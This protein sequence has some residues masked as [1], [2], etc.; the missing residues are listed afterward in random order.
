MK[1][2]LANLTIGITL[3]AGCALQPLPD[4]IPEPIT[5]VMFH[6]NSGPMCL[7]A[8]DWLASMQLE[9]PT[10]IVDEHLTYE[11]GEADMLT[12]LEADFA[13]SEGV[14]VHFEYLP[15]IFVRE[16]AFSGFNDEVADSLRELLSGAGNARR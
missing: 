2:T 10:L 13:T 14:S 6:N 12:Q 5:L 11:T 3:V 7:D 4:S 9:Y 16:R 1:S 8:L 15:I